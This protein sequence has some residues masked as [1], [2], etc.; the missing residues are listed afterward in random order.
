MSAPAVKEIIPDFTLDS[1]EGTPVTLLSY[2]ARKNLVMIFVCGGA[3]KALAWLDE[4]ARRKDTFDEENARVLVVLHGT[5]EQARELRQETDAPFVFLADCDGAEHR[6]FGALNSEGW[7][8]PALYITDQYGEVYSS[9]RTLAGEPLP[10]ADQVLASLRHIN[11][12]C[13]E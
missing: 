5:V 8:G 11:I 12:K 2:R 7:S 6:R 1:S 9:H 10:D 4:A 13:D 3:G